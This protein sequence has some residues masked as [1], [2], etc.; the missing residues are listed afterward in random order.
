MVN[1]PKK[2][3]SFGLAKKSRIVDDSKLE[4]HLFQRWSQGVFKTNSMTLSPLL[5]PFSTQFLAHGVTAF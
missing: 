5:K 3:Q 1:K 4:I 2:H